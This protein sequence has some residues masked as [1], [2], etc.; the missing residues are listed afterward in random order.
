MVSCND[1]LQSA[2]TPLDPLMK[3]D[4]SSATPALEPWKDLPGRC[5]YFY[6]EDLSLYDDF[7]KAAI[8][9]MTSILLACSELRHIRDR[10]RSD[11][12]I[13]EHLRDQ[14]HPSHH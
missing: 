10:E 13:F 12:A 6:F 5:G 14:Y 11:F 2:T 1:L 4:L 3:N 9:S 8:P 7:F